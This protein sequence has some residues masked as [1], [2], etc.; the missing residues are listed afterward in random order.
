MPIKRLLAHSDSFR[1]LRTAFFLFYAALIFYTYFPA[2]HHYF[3]ADDGQWLLHSAN[4]RSALKPINGYVR[5]ATALYFFTM[6]RVFGLFPVPYHFM[7]IAFHF[8]NVCVF[9]FFVKELLVFF[10]GKDKESSLNILPAFS[11]FFYSIPFSVFAAIIWIS[12]IHD[13]LMTFFYLLSLLFALKSMN[14]KKPYLFFPSFFSFTVSLM[15]K[16]HAITL[17]FVIFPLLIMSACPK[18]VKRNAA[19]GYIFIP[20]VFFVL[21]FNFTTFSKNPFA[22]AYRLNFQA[23]ANF[24]SLSAEASASFFGFSLHPRMQEAGS[25][26]FFKI[27]QAGALF[28]FFVLLI[29]S[30]QKR[31]S[32]HKKAVLFGLYFFAINIFPLCFFTYLS[33]PLD[34]FAARYRYFYLPF[35]GLCL[36]FSG[37]IAA[38]PVQKQKYIFLKIVLALFFSLNTAINITVNKIPVS[39]YGW[40]SG[41]NATLVQKIMVSPYMLHRKNVVVVSDEPAFSVLQHMLKDYLQLY[42][43]KE[44]KVIW[45]TT[46][47]LMNT[48]TD[49]TPGSS[50]FIVLKPQTFLDSTM[51]MDKILQAT[52]NPEPH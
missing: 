20:I 26:A 52:K 21:Y 31:S 40:M 16:E 35:S 6:R 45:L 19:A 1:R 25:L 33:S 3:L 15:F 37:L 47:E 48:L 5:P 22:G 42:L 49:F 11:S 14:T 2:L 41:M 24:F 23:L 50:V 43:K 51:Q 4:F 10:K 36:A 7:N 38:P 18:S 12:G 27:L 29:L 9:F 17:P 8:L 44:V 46:T 32:W 28:S 13:I 34:A 30:S 39:G